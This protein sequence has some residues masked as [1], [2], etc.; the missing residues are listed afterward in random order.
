MENIIRKTV[1]VCFLIMAMIISAQN[2]AIWQ[3]VFYK[4]YEAE[5]TGKYT[6]AIN[7]L[8]KVYKTDNYFVNIRMGWLHY[9]SR[10][11]AE[12][13]KYYLNAIRLK[14]YSIEARFGIVKP[15]S[16][17]EQWEKVKQ[18]Y[19]QIL[20][21]DPQNTI[22]NYWLGVIYYNRKD[23]LNAVKLFEKVVNLYPLDYDSVIMLAWT[24][25]NL[26]KQAEAS[27]LF[28]H[29]ITLRPNDESAT[30]GLK[31]IK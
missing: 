25:L 29:A 17:T 26:G 23:Y 5:K 13:E 10:Q 11:H 9:L 24:K 14:P 3:Q 4:S 22:A 8:K 6:I 15:Y 1:T 28:N 2:Q 20:K 27:I 12:A 19:H 21:I 16:A 30:S 7:E 18:Q 31:L